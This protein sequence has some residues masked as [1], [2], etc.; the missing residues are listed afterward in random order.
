MAWGKTTKDLCD[1]C[2]GIHDD[3]VME[4]ARL[5]VYHNCQ[6]DN[7]PKNDC[8]LALDVLDLQVHRGC[9]WSTGQAL[10]YPPRSK[11]KKIIE[12]EDPDD[13]TTRDRVNM[14]NA[15]VKAIQDGILDA[16]ED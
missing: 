2:K 5:I 4:A 11:V 15:G 16:L 13:V 7:C 1:E 6:E 8:H 14:F 12:G 10:S 9:G 3:T